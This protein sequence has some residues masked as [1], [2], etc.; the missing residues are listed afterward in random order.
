MTFH[1]IL[2]LVLIIH[3]LF[4][5]TPGSPSPIIGVP[6]N[7]PNGRINQNQECGN[8]D[9]YFEMESQE[10]ENVSTLNSGNKA[11]TNDVNNSTK[12]PVINYTLRTQGNCTVII[13]KPLD[14]NVKEL[15]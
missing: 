8:E 3:N 4:L 11:M 12:L 5:E 1:L 13:I 9:Q 7:S 14:N 6:H 2:I 15:I 10:I